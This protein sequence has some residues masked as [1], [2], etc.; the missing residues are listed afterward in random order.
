M[1]MVA[2]DWLRSDKR[3]D[4]LGGRPGSIVQVGFFALVF[5]FLILIIFSHQETTCF[6]FL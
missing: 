2:A 4:D 1:Q 6:I 5:W 3:E